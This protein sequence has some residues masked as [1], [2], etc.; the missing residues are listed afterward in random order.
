[1]INETNWIK[2]FDTFSHTNLPFIKAISDQTPSLS[3]TQFKVCT[4]LRAGHS[5]NY[6][7]KELNISIRAVENHRYQLRQKLHIKHGENLTAH[8]MRY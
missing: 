4:Y 6:I 3:D 2:F 5:T 8:L 1:M 7:A